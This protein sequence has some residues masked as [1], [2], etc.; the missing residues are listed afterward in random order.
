MPSL[1]LGSFYIKDTALI[2]DEK[3][4]KRKNEKKKKNTYCMACIV[5]TLSYYILYKILY[6]RCCTY[7]RRKEKTKKKKIHCMACIVGTLSGFILPQNG[8]QH[9]ELTTHRISTNL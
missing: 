2:A 9:P 8:N 3:K 4:K 6:K 5:G 1:L 7:N